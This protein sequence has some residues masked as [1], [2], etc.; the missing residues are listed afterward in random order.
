MFSVIHLK[1]QYFTIPN[2]SK[3]I[4]L[5]HNTNITI[6]DIIVDFHSYYFLF[7]VQVPVW[8]PSFAP[9]PPKKGYH[10]SPYRLR[11]GSHFLLSHFFWDRIFLFNFSAELIS[12]C[13]VGKESVY[14]ENPFSLSTCH[15]FFKLR[16]LAVGGQENE[17]R[18]TQIELI[19]FV[20]LSYSL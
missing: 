11:Q 15:D 3:I 12:G 5:L 2:Q 8:P 16:H 20:S 18:S 14:G 19:P 13:N 9:S 4:F 1:F 7:G 6:F 17:V 10:N